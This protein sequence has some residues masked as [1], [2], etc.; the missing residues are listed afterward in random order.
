M[1]G[2]SKWGLK[3][4]QSQLTEALRTDPVGVQVS[5]STERLRNEQSFEM[6][7]L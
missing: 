4:V 2:L 1:S 3:Y 5:A 6:S 7:F